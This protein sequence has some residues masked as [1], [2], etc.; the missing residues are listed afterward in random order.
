LLALLL[1]RFL[2]TQQNESCAIKLQVVV[3]EMEKNKSKT[4][5]EKKEKMLFTLILAKCLAA[6]KHFSSVGKVGK[7]ILEEI[8]DEAQVINE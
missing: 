4:E 7:K 5:N 2:H 1:E 6:T 8:H 3:E